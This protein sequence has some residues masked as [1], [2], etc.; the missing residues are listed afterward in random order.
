MKPTRTLTEPSSPANQC[1][2]LVFVVIPARK[3]VMDGW[4]ASGRPGET[5]HSGATDRTLRSWEQQGGHRP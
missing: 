2:L 3:P 1:A 4:R 5:P